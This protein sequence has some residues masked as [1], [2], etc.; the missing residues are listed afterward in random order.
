MKKYLYLLLVAIFATMPLVLT[1]CGDDDEPDGGNATEAMIK[2]YIVGEEWSIVEVEIDG[3]WVKYPD[4]REYIRPYAINLKLDTDGSFWTWGDYT[5]KGSK[6]D[7]YVGGRH[8][9]TIDVLSVSES[10]YEAIMTEYGNNLV[11]SYRAKCHK[12]YIF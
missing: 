7:L 8:D 3:S 12:G 9:L 2:K 6:I 1:S 10:E 4:Y 11:V 5:I